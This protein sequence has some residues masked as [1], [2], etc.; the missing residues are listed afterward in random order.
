MRR[1]AADSL[2]KAETEVPPHIAIDLCLGHKADD[3]HPAAK[4]AI[5]PESD[6]DAEPGIERQAA[7]VDL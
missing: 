3:G 6:T 4:S 2:E 5:F 7:V 1:P